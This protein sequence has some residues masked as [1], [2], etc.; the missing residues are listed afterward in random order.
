MSHQV[1]YIVFAVGAVVGSLVLS[2]MSSPFFTGI[3]Y[4]VLPTLLCLYKCLSLFMDTRR[5]MQGTIDLEMSKLA[6]EA[7]QTIRLTISVGSEE[8]ILRKFEKLQDLR[9]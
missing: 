3:L 8:H 7:M 6:M 4:L 1:G 9:K 5:G 2:L